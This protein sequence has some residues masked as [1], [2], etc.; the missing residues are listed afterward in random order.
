MPVYEYQC[1]DCSR[2]FELFVQHRMLADG[3]VC[4]HCHSPEVR[5]LVS[6]FASTG[7]GEDA[8]FAASATGGGCGGGCGGCSGGNCGACGH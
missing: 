7:R 1:N 4:R 2:K 6:S 8:D 3:I 5:K